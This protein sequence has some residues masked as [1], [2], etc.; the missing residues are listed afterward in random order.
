M[1]P[2]QVWLCIVFA[3][4]EGARERDE[5]TD[6]QYVA[7]I[8]TVTERFGRNTTHLVIDEALRATRKDAAA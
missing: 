7:F 4:L 3:A 6:A 8:F 5:I 2:L 1:T